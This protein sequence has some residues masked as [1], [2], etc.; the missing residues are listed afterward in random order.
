MVDSAQGIQVVIKA[1]ALLLLVAF[2]VACLQTYRLDDAKLA[3]AQRDAADAKAQSDSQAHAGETSQSMLAWIFNAGD[4]YDRGKSD[5]KTIA[6]RTF[7]DLHT[8]NLRVRHEWEVCE[9]SR[10]ADSA[11]A[12]SALAAAIERRNELASAAIGIGATCDAYQKSMIDAYD[13]VRKLVNGDG[14]H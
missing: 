11:A 2:A 6:D 4:A 13:G 14:A 10:V 5:A 12:R 7:A 9:T 8:G 1:L 3:L